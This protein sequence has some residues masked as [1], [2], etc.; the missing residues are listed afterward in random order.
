MSELCLFLQESLACGYRILFSF[1]FSFF[2][3]V[4]GSII[5]FFIIIFSLDN[6]VIRSLIFSLSISVSFCGWWR[7]RFG[8]VF[9]LEV[10]FLKVHYYCLWY[11]SS[12]SLTFF[13]FM[14]ISLS[15]LLS[16][17]GHSWVYLNFHHRIV[18]YFF[19]FFSSSII[20]ILGKW[21]RS[22]SSYFFF[23][24]GIISIILGDGCGYVINNSIF[25]SLFFSL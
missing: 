20:W 21:L 5:T 12:N 8:I 18:V 15:F 24:S 4:Y 2:L 3:T 14:E 11:F 10:V 1:I 9:L 16:S 13:G 25:L 17:L 7:L 19:H 23:I 6:P 22:T